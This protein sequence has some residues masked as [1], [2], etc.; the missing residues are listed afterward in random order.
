GKAYYGDHALG[1]PIAGTEKSVR[2]LGRDHLLAHQEKVKAHWPVVVSA[3]G[4]LE[5]A[6]VVGVAAEA[7]GSKPV[8]GSRKPAVR[9]QKR[10]ETPAK[11]AHLVEK[12]KVQQVNVMLGGPGYDARHPKKHAL[13]LLNS[14][15]GDGMSSRLFQSVR[16]DLG[17]V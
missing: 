4:A 6:E 11:R 2:G 15:F 14:V 13:I 16:E 8:A 9:A 5:H 12:R 1:Y 3:V 10:A 17:L 7:F